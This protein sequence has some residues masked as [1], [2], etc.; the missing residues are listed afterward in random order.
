LLARK[1]KNELLPEKTKYPYFT[2][3]VKGS[4]D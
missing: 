1:Q 3:E 4:D 2:D